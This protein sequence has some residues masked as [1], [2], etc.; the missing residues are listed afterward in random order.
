MATNRTAWFDEIG[1]EGGPVLVANLEDFLQWH[2]SELLDP[3]SATELHYW[4]SFTAELPQQWQ[5]NGPSGHQY[6]ACANPIQARESLMALLTERWP[7][8]K[9]DR[10]DST[11]RAVRPDGKALNA[12][13]SPDSE[14]DRAIRDLGADGVHPYAQGA[15]AYLWSARP[16]MVRI[17]IDQTRRHMMLSQVEYADDDTDVQAAYMHA[18]NAPHDHVQPSQ[19]YQITEGP[20]VVAWAP[21]SARDGPISKSSMGTTC[22]LP[23]RLLDLSTAGS[24]ALLWLEPG[25]YQSTLHY[26]EEGNWA[27]S[28]C[29]LQRLS[30]AAAG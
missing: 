30:P 22:S 13:L 12:A 16:G 27:V 21:N 2:G 24:G 14:Y 18:L 7:G 25:H 23:G 4:S 15:S 26:H 19:Q 17:D 29:R 28:S 6:L 10:S 3:S 11:W 20:I 5:P 9:V 8:T 1:C